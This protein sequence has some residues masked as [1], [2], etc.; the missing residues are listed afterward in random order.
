MHGDVDASYY[1]IRGREREREREREILSLG[2]EGKKGQEDAINKQILWVFGICV[3]GF[4][5]IGKCFWLEKKIKKGKM[6]N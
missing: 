1:I 3:M 4:F 2:G 6:L 5:S